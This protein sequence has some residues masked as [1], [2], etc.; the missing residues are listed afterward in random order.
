MI[1]TKKEMFF[2]I[3]GTEPT[4]NQTTKDLD[5]VFKKKKIV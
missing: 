3:K 4:L 2:Y 1:N 5:A